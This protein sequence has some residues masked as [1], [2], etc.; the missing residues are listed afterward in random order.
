MTSGKN[1]APKHGAPHPL[2]YA[3]WPPCSAWPPRS[4]LLRLSA[5]SLQQSLQQ[6]F[7]VPCCCC[8]AGVI[9]PCG[10]GGGA[11]C[12]ATAAAIINVIIVVLLSFESGSN[13]RNASEAAWPC[14]DE[15]RPACERL[16]WPWARKRPATIARWQAQSPEAP[17]R[18]PWCTRRSRLLSRD[19]VQDRGN[20]GSAWRRWTARALPTLVREPYRT[21]AATPQRRPTV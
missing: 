14:R 2:S 12:A 4:A 20:A 19:P 11:G 10:F 8:C 16:R 3:P 9:W 6:P 13:L 17:R 18:R 15:G 21:A 7:I 1:G 5:M